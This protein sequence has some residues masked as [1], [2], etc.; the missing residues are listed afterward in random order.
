MNENIR[1]IA[2][3][4]ISIFDLSCEVKINFEYAIKHENRENAHLVWFMAHQSRMEL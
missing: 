3:A 2:Y 4:C 1:Y